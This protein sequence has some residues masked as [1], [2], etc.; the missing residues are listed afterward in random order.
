MV[1]TD[2]LLQ[3][4]QTL[5]VKM[6]GGSMMEFSIIQKTALQ[7]GCTLGVKQNEEDCHSPLPAA[8]ALSAHLQHR[9]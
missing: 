7:P 5:K 2:R 3:M 6:K 9:Q 1:L 8:G 4:D